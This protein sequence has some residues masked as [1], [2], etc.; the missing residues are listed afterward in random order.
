MDCIRKLYLSSE[1]SDDAESS[2][3]V[4][5]FQSPASDA[6]YD[7]ATLPAVFRENSP[8]QDS[9]VEENFSTPENKCRLDVQNQFNDG[10]RTNQYGEVCFVESGE[11]L[12]SS[13][14]TYGNCGFPTRNTIVSSLPCLN[15]QIDPNATTSCTHWRWVSENGREMYDADLHHC[16]TAAF[17]RHSPNELDGLFLVDSKQTISG[18][19]CCNKSML[20]HENSRSCLSKPM[21]SDSYAN[22]D[23]MPEEFTNASVIPSDAKPIV[24]HVSNGAYIPESEIEDCEVSSL[25]PV[26]CNRSTHTS[27][28][29]CDVE[30]DFTGSSAH[31]HKF[32]N[33]GAVEQSNS[34]L[35]VSV[36][37]EA[38]MNKLLPGCRD[39]SSEIASKRVYWNRLDGVLTGKLDSLCNG[40]THNDI[41]KSSI[42][43]NG[44]N[45]DGVSAKCVP[46]HDVYPTDFCPKVNS[47]DTVELFD[48]NSTNKIDALA[49]V[50]EPDVTV[51]KN[52]NDLS[53]SKASFTNSEIAYK[54]ENVALEKV[55]VENCKTCLDIARSGRRQD[56]VSHEDET[57]SRKDDSEATFEEEVQNMP[58]KQKE[59]CHTFEMCKAVHGAVKPLHSEVFTENKVNAFSKNKQ[60]KNLLETKVAEKSGT[61]SEEDTYVRSASVGESDV[62]HAKPWG[63]TFR[64][65]Y[66]ESVLESKGATINHCIPLSNDLPLGKW[67]NQNPLLANYS[68][69]KGKQQADAIP[70][71]NKPVPAMDGNAGSILSENSCQTDRHILE[72]ERMEFPVDFDKVC[73]DIPN[74]STIRLETPK[75]VTFDHSCSSE[76]VFADKL[77]HHKVFSCVNSLESPSAQHLSSEFCSIPSCLESTR[78]ISQCTGMNKDDSESLIDEEELQGLGQSMSGKDA[79]SAGIKDKVKY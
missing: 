44:N 55:A 19:L 1:E 32:R 14:M 15:C 52:L 27:K 23:D 34:N 25:S 26:S 17:V 38:N 11:S 57:H 9:V 16:R 61:D 79:Y 73:L 29:H 62:L 47:I 76:L 40:F 70:S 71:G 66:G 50:I 45:G 35:E 42:V 41:Y 43:T 68:D 5:E 67:I 33:L 18:E 30:D 63:S 53:M 46:P 2:F 60:G 6:S 74:M 37:D 22:L 78:D 21:P 48:A 75:K 10:M 64:V 20:W 7:D 31:F 39:V 12:S 69:F 51:T 54:G 3:Q 56:D 77:V 28:D 8:G 49:A 72:F 58:V 24:S 59:S 13:S 65:N 4:L 36:I